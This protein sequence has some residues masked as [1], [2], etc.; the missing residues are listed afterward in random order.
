MTRQ[1]RIALPLLAALLLAAVVGVAGCG[2]SS[3]SKD[4]SEGQSVK[5]GVI[6]YQVV[7][8]RYL[9][10]ADQEDSAY[11][12]G[13]PEPAAGT[14]YFGVFFQVKNEGDETE[15]LPKSFTITDSEEK[16]FTSI[17]STSLFAFPL[18]GELETE[19]WIPLDGSTAQQGPIEGSLVLF[20][21]PAAASESRPWTLTINGPEGPAKVKLDV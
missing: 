4:V 19:E 9:N 15:P 18:G 21:I 5:L 10:P 16:S 3:S 1:P 17:P 6:K 11:L 20:R 7:F 2:Y 8:S 14:N 12:V 13:Q